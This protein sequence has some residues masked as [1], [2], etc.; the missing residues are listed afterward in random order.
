MIALTNL[1]RRAPKGVLAVAALVLTIFC[2]TDDARAQ[3]GGMG[4]LM[5]PMVDSKEVDAL[6]QLLKL[7]ADAETAVRDLFV[8]FQSQHAAASE[9]LQEIFQ[10]AQEEAQRNNDMTV[11]QDMQKKA[12][13]FYKSQ[14][15][16]RDRLFDDIKLM[17][18]PEQLEKWP[19]FE[20]LHR[21]THLLDSGQNLVAGSTVDL[22]QLVDDTRP[23]S[24][25]A[26]APEV[27]DM[28]NR[29][30]ADLDRI[31]I[32]SRDLQ[33]EQLEQTQKML[34][35]GGNFMANLEQWSKM[36]NDARA[37]Q[38]KV[39]ELNARY[40]RQIAGLLSDA[41]RAEFSTEY[42]RRANPRVYARNYVDGAFDTALGLESLSAEQ[43]EQVVALQAEYR[44]AAQPICEKWDA[45][46]AEWQSQVQ[47]MEMFSPG[48]GS[49]QAKEF[50]QAKKDLD[51][52]TYSRLR[53]ILTEEQ[54]SALPE[55]ETSNWR[56]EPTFDGN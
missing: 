21:R 1:F 38:V 32:E 45:A 28:L 17:L 41:Q 15:T 44:A 52:Q 27:D 19:D 24:S 53:G 35:E 55:R 20:R 37:L 42:N 4:A 30:A 22:V 56:T 13:E 9:K 23:K 16:A 3:M 10:K 40:E 14:L 5:R 26:N 43:R 33:A 25:E 31:L 39:R 11:I 29:Y 34:A 8:A 46:L 51:E 7:D 12:L 54:A 18:T 6:V 47:M 49:A 36:F 48:A 50:E 2:T